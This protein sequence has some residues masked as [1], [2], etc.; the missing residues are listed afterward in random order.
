MKWIKLSKR[1]I[2]LNRWWIKLV[3]KFERFEFVV[4]DAVERIYKC[5]Y[6]YLGGFWFGL[7]C[8][9]NGRTVVNADVY[10]NVFIG[11]CV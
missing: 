11:V 6:N 2:K 1:W 9:G 4:I 8:I 5:K 10:L 7:V 3:D